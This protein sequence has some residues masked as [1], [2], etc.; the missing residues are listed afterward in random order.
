MPSTQSELFDLPP[1]PSRSTLA[2]RKRKARVE[3]LK[4]RHDIVTDP[5]RGVSYCQ[6]IALARF[7]EDAKKGMTAI[8]C[9][10]HSCR[11][12]EEA[13]QL[14]YGKTELAAVLELCRLNNLATE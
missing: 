7:E 10:A 14:A 9:I 8:D 5:P 4:A 11:L 12:Y 6:W 3:A 13:G 1:Q 2:R